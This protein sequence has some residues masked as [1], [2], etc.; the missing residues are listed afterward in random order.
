[1]RME[2]MK[3]CHRIHVPAC[4]PILTR[5]SI[6]LLYR[7]VKSVT[8][9]DEAAGIKSAEY[10]CKG[11]NLLTG[12]P[13][14]SASS[15]LDPGFRQSVCRQP[16]NQ[17][18]RTS[19][20][21][22]MTPLGVDVFPT[23]SCQFASTST[24][25]T[26]EEQLTDSL[27]REASLDASVKAS[28]SGG[29][30]AEASVE[31]SYSQSEKVTEFRNRQATQQSVAFEAR[32][33]CTEFTLRF[34]PNITK[35]ITSS[36]AQA[37]A[38]LP[39]TYT[40]DNQDIFA[41]FLNNFG[42]HYVFE[43]TLGGKH[44]YTSYMTSNDVLTLTR[45]GSD[46]SRTLSL[47][48]QASL[49][50]STKDEEEAE[51][52][53]ANVMEEGITIEISNTNGGD[54]GG[55]DSGPSA[56]VS[57]S[58]ATT[59][60]QSRENRRKVAS[61][62]TEVTEMNIGGDPPSAPNAWTEWANSVKFN[63]MPVA[64]KFQTFQEFMTAP[65]YEAFNEAIE[66]IYGLN[67]NPPMIN[68]TFLDRL[69]FGVA[70]LEGL[71]ISSY[72][73]SPASNFRTTLVRSVR[74]VL[75]STESVPSV[76]TIA[77]QSA[78]GGSGFGSPGNVGSSPDPGKC[79]LAGMKF[80]RAND[81]LVDEEGIVGIKLIFRR[82]LDWSECVEVPIEPYATSDVQFAMSECPQNQFV[83]GAKA[84]Y[85]VEK[86][87]NNNDK[88]GL[89]AITLSCDRA[90]T[91]NPSSLNQVL[92]SRTMVS[93]A[94]T[95]VLRDESNFLVSTVA[96]QFGPSGRNSFFAEDIGMRGLQFTFTQVGSGP[97][98]GWTNRLWPIE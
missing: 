82:F 7:T 9:L 36:F 54:G 18:T 43:L 85:G 79:Y 46:V 65:Q 86:D 15:Q 35:S 88:A 92:D 69:H 34:Q 95:L 19:N 6:G 26:T 53:D 67:L 8:A 38:A 40:A 84:D 2:R 90:D 81:G 76:R 52:G 83:V 96:I 66:K 98:V 22:F 71:P 80:F 75:G 4:V 50:S 11:Y 3:R 24:E 59:Q 12:N 10:L 60:S 16:T 64:Y 30:F 32:A 21:R 20:R 63:P 27:T 45:E 97:S 31:L 17:E 73:D 25:I 68:S 29:P 58:V 89:V 62:I 91:N 23:V 47:S 87:N 42:T 48:V 61:R 28:G 57:R 77:Q 1:M 39:E 5:S 93:S 14:G 94:G 41:A 51:D 37:V 44:I 74:E 13:R 56:M 33:L 72:S 55:G 49:A 78:V 70:S